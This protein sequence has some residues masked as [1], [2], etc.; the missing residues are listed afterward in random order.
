MDQPGPPVS[1]KRTYEVIKSF[2][3]SVNTSAMRAYF[4]SKEDIYRYLKE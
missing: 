1:K 3:V 2:K 4:A